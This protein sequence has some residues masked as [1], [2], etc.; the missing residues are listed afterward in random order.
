MDEARAGSRSRERHVQG[1]GHQ[2]GLEMTTHRPAT[3]LAR[4]HVD[5]HREIEEPLRGGDVRDVRD[6]ERA[7]R[8]CREGAVHHEKPFVG[9]NCI[10]RSVFISRAG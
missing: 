9:A 4:D 5:D 1:A 2:L 6:P 10:R 7:G 3:D 8:V